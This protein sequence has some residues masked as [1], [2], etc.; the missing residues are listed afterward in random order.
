M[1]KN[2]Y[3]Y[4]DLIIGNIE[5]G[6]YSPV[7]HYSAAMGKSGETMFGMDRIWGGSDI[8]DSASGK[9][10]WSLVDANSASWP[11]NYKGGSTGNKLKRLAAEMMY[12]RYKKYSKLYL[13]AKAQKLVDKSQKLQIHFF[14][15]CWNGAGYFK[16]FA[17]DINT[18]VAKGEKDLKKLQDVAINSR[19]RHSVAL[20]RKGGNKMLN[21]WSKMKDTPDYA[22]IVFWCVM[23]AVIIGTGIYFRKEIAGVWRKIISSPKC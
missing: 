17:S 5:G 1:N 10:F 22:K 20:I 2:F 3:N 9:K 8:N 11:Y 14:Y 7:R 23:A 6:Y 21:I 12:N 18:A 19:L 13:S 16:Q 4:A 15:A